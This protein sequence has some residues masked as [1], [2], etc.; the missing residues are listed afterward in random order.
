[1]RRTCCNCPGDGNRV[2]GQ[3]TCHKYPSRDSL[4][5]L[6]SVTTDLH[7][8]DLGQLHPLFGF[9]LSS[10]THVS[11]RIELLLSRIIASPKKTIELTEKN[12]TFPTAAVTY[13][14]HRP[15]D[16]RFGHATPQTP[17]SCHRLKLL[18][19]P[20]RSIRVHVRTTFFKDKTTGYLTL[21][22][23]LQE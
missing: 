8:L 7:L 10:D 17:E 2:I 11:P 18:H 20:A 9:F 19:P 4:E 5:R 21:E 22:L 1:M 6:T 12:T 15:A 16:N 3:V 14:Y 23:L 13:C